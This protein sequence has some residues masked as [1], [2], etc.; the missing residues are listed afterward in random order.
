MSTYGFLP[1]TLISLIVYFVSYFLTKTKYLKFV[2]H[3]R[4]WNLILLVTFFIAGTLGIFM[5]VIYSFELNIN[6]P[7]VLLQIHVGVGTVWF[8]IAFFHF[9]WHLT[10]FK[11]AIKVIFSS[12]K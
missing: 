4:I 2:K 7:Y 9:L 8:I 10:Y 11:K 6:I 12:S 5:T 3:R 1:I